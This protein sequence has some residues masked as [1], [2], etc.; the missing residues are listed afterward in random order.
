MRKAKIRLI[1]G[2]ALLLASIPPA[3]PQAD[4]AEAAGKLCRAYC[5]LVNMICQAGAV[6]TGDEEPCL[7]LYRGC[8]DGCD[9][10]A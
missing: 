7:H 6:P 5:E 8:V 10:E 2:L 4:A 1:A 3:P 9:V